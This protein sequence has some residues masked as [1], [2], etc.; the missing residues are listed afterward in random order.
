MSAAVGAFWDTP[1]GPRSVTSG[2]P[3]TASTE[4]GRYGSPLPHSSVWSWKARTGA[5]RSASSC[6][7]GPAAKAGVATSAAAM[8]PSVM[9]R[10][11]RLKPEL[12]RHTDRD[13]VLRDAGALTGGVIG[14]HRTED[15]VAAR[16]ILLIVEEDD[17]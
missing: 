17:R 5:Y 4:I 1:F 15:C 11:R 14:R 10:A 6:A 12:R 3:R 9:S 16:V 13:V 7:G 2:L 8:R